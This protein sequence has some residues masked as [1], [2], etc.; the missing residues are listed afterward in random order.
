MYIPPSFDLSEM[1]KAYMVI[2][3]PRSAPLSSAPTWTLDYALQVFGVDPTSAQAI[4]NAYA[5]NDFDGGRKIFIT[6]LTNMRLGIT[7][8][9]PKGTG[10]INAYPPVCFIYRTCLIVHLPLPTLRGSSTRAS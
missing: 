7:Q 9:A 2:V 8:D 5:Q 6:F 4:T 3:Y 1:D 10:N